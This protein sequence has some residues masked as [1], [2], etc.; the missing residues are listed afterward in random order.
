MSK[1]CTHQGRYDGCIECARLQSKE[2]DISG[3]LKELIEALYSSLGMMN[4]NSYRLILSGHGKE[5]NILRI[6]EKYEKILNK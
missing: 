6:I 3:A 1:Y 4:E 2:L 5:K